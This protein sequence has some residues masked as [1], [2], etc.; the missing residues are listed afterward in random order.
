[1][2]QWGFVGSI[3]WNVAMNHQIYRLIVTKKSEEKL[4]SQ[5]GI[6]R[7]RPNHCR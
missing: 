6:V 5:T 1:M 4:T 3:L 2:L 7:S